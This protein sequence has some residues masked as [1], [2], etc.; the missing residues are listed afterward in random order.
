MDTDGNRL[1]IVEALIL[2]S[3]EPLPARKIIG[4]VEDLTP[5]ELDKIVSALN[6][7]YQTSDSSFRIR[8]IAG[9]FQV[10]IIDN[11][12]GFVEELFTRRR[13]LRLTR[14]A[15]ETMA[16]I[17]YRQPVTKSDIE[18]IRGV[19]SD[20]ALHTLLQ[21]KFITISGRANTLGRPLL[22]SSTDEFLKFFDL[23]GLDDLP[24]MS[25]IEEL[26]ADSEPEV[27]R[28]LVFGPPE[29]SAG[30]IPSV[31][32]DDQNDDDVQDVHELDQNI[33]LSEA[34]DGNHPGITA[35]NTQVRDSSPV[36]DSEYNSNDVLDLT[37]NNEDMTDQP[38][39]ETEIEEKTTNS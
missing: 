7:K 38:D 6:E 31:T 24:R 26:L 21:K 11:Y 13:T 39:S 1:P 4:V 27:Q 28:S 29:E 9:G 20:S 8:K 18:M 10:Y 16:I 3:P 19:A 22:Y 17:A 32:S 35:E 37:E 5:G 33:D 36:D 15:L 34:P 30:E 12:A 2:S 14:A 23:A 25:E